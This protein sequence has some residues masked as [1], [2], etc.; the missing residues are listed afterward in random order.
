[1]SYRLNVSEPLDAALRRIVDGQIGRKEARSKRT[2]AATPTWV[3]DT[4]KSLKR[5]RALLRLLRS[6][7]SKKE[8]RRANDD[9]RQIGR[10][11]SALRERD[12]LPQTIEGLRATAEPDV[13][14]ALDRLAVAFQ[15]APKTSAERRAADPLYEASKSLSAAAARL[16]DLRFS[17]TARRILQEG[18]AA[19]HDAG[20]RALAATRRDPADEA[21]HDLRK[22]VQIHWRQMQLLERAW[23]DALRVR[24]TTAKDVAQALGQH[25]DLAMLIEALQ[26]AA[27]EGTANTDIASIVATCR[28]TQTALRVRAL[29]LTA[30]LFAADPHAFAA[31]VMTYWRLAEGESEARSK[32]KKKATA[33]KL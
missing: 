22:V 1:M 9:L 26:E 29:P 24:I 17:G 4:R 27:P 12:V 33:S 15:Q 20:Q 28:H 3:H 10:S 8:W 5:V 21:V 30:R 18:L 2:T 6:G 23:P 19:T 7:L 25:Q 31:E 32:L 16:K 13:V 11:L 14:A